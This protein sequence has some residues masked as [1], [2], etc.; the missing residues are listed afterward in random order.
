MFL[1]VLPHHHML[2]V[3][4][5]LR[6]EPP[7]TCCVP[8]TQSRTLSLPVASRQPIINSLQ[9]FLNIILLITFFSFSQPSAAVA[10]R[11]C[12]PLEPPGKIWTCLHLMLSHQINKATPPSRWY[13]F[14]LFSPPLVTGI[15]SCVS[16]Q[17]RL[18]F[19]KWAF[20]RCQRWTEFGFT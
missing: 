6:L 11:V 1:P 8:T 19:C 7:A 12:V 18:F 10:H 4:R 15:V 2:T 16:R 3:Q 14:F 17:M 20:W 5:R 13:F 9:P